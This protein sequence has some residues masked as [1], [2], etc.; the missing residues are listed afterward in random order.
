[1]HIHPPK[2]KLDSVKKFLLELLTITCGILI[3]LSL[4]GAMEWTHHRHLLR[5]AR[6]N[7]LS[8]LHGNRATIAASEREIP[9][10]LGNLQKVMNLCRQERS[11]RGSV[12]L[13]KERKAFHSTSPRGQQVR[14][15]GAPHNQPALLT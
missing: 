14:P 7:I 8:E 2:E 11:H 13:E 5:E 3:A 15:V 12:N 4:E 10:E 1:M 6:S 9:A